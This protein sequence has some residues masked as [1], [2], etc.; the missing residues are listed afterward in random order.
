M[1]KYPAVPTL[2]DAIARFRCIVARLS[3]VRAWR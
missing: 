1:I 3:Y 2:I